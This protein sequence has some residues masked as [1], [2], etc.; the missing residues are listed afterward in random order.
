MIYP[1]DL[2]IY[3]DD[4]IVI[5]NAMPVYLY[6]S[7]DYDNINFRVWMN[8]VKDAVKDTVCDISP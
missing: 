6:K 7:L 5:T 2:K 3:Q 4:I 8:N 1:A